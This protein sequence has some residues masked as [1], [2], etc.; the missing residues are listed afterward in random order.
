MKSIMKYSTFKAIIYY[1]DEHEIFH[2]KVINKNDLITFE[3]TSVK[4]LKNAFKEAIKDYNKIKNS[5][6]ERLTK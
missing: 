4:K 6:K 2:G 5:R 3:G 1:N